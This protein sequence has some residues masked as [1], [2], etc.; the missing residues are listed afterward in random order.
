MRKIIMALALCLPLAVNA[1]ISETANTPVQKVKVGETFT[2]QLPSNPTTGYGWVVKKAPEQ[3]KLLNK[4]YEQS[5]ECKKGMVGCGGV[6]S[7]HFNAIQPGQGLLK[8]KYVRSW[9]EP[10]AN[11]AEKQIIIEVK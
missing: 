7:F 2:I 3:I 11:D 6:Q 10:S 8:L 5:P 9:E 1:E 4:S